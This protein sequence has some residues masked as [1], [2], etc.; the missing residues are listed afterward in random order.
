M[1]ERRQP[2]I[3]RPVVRLARRGLSRL[4][5]QHS[6]LAQRVQGLVFT[7]EVF[8]AGFGKDGRMV[9]NAVDPYAHRVSFRHLGGGLVG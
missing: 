9:E 4:L 6:E 8:V 7:E 2:A 3:A 5:P 1:S